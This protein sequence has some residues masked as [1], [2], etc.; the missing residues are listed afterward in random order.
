MSCEFRF[1]N[2]RCWRYSVSGWLPLAS[3]GSGGRSGRPIRRSG[4]AG[5][6]Q[7]RRFPSLLKDHHEGYIDW[8]EFERNQGAP[9]RQRLRHGRQGMEFVAS[10]S[11]YRRRQIPRSPMIPFAARTN[12]AYLPKSSRLTATNTPTS[13][14]GTR[15]DVGHERAT[16]AALLQAHR[17]PVMRGDGEPAKGMPCQEYGITLDRECN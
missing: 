14:P 1:R 9:R 3:S 13:P 16:V 7:M 2:L 5:Y 15:G 8:A 12:P 11:S 10:V 17:H 6:G 4:L